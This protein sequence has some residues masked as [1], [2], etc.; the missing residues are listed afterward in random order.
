MAD[1]PLLTITLSK[2]GDEFRADL[3]APSETNG[4]A[5]LRVHGVHSNAIEA[6]EI[7]LT[8]LQAMAADNDEIALRF[9]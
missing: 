2:R 4:V 3:Q 8:E 9:T 1:E 6:I 5:D 7:C